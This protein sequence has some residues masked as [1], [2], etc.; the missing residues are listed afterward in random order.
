MP[1]NPKKSA[2][3]WVHKMYEPIC[4]KISIFPSKMVQEIIQYAAGQPKHV[5]VCRV[6]GTD[7]YLMQYLMLLVQETKQSSCLLYT[8]PSPRD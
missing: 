1:L 2:R 7:Q 6:G 4:A 5:F 3:K 8:S